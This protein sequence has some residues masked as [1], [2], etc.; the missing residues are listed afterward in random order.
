MYRACDLTA[1]AGAG[2]NSFAGR[3]AASHRDV[4]SQNDQDDR[5]STTC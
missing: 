5:F 3:E 1:P 4:A 2:A